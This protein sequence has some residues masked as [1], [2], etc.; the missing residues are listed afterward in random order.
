MK[1]RC[2]KTLLVPCILLIALA[3]AK[4]AQAYYPQYGYGGGGFYVGPSY[5]ASRAGDLQAFHTYPTFRAYY[6]GPSRYPLYP[7]YPVGTYSAYPVVYPTYPVYPVVP[8]Y[9]VYP[10]Y[11]YGGYNW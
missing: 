6:Y 4:P 7:A 5:G 9:D 2:L 11:G 1:S 10:S 3:V 8:V